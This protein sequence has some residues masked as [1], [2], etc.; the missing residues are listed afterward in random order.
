MPKVVDRRNPTVRQWYRSANLALQVRRPRTSPR[1][2]LVFRD[3]PVIRKVAGS[4]V[5]V[6]PKEGIDLAVRQQGA[7]LI[8]PKYLAC[9]VV[10]YDRELAP[11]LAAVGREYRRRLLVGRANVSLWLPCL[12]RVHPAV[13]RNLEQR[14]CAVPS[15]PLAWQGNGNDLR[16]RPLGAAVIRPEQDQLAA[17]GILGIEIEEAFLLLEARR[18]HQHPAVR[19]RRYPRRAVCPRIEAVF[20]RVDAAAVVPRLAVGRAE[21]LHMVVR[22]AQLPSDVL[23]CDERSTGQRR[24]DGHVCADAAPTGNDAAVYDFEHRGSPVPERRSISIELAAHFR[25]MARCPIVI[26]PLMTRSGGPSDTGPPVA[27]CASASDV[28]P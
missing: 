20:R 11:C 9:G 19:R 23:G 10:G 13:V 14:P 24:D 12:E 15:V 5:E 16:S 27:S 21:H 2:P 25:S 6:R 1:P 3:R 26:L 7:H 28:V 4:A 8:P 17:C 22:R 18:R